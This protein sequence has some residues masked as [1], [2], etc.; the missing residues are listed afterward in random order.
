MLEPGVPGRAVPVLDFGRDI[1]YVA[2]FQRAGGL[3]P[4]LIPAAAGCYQK[5][6]TSFVMDVPVV[7]APRFKGDVAHAH[8]LCGEHGQIACS[9]KILCKGGIRCV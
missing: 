1:D 7:A 3:A 6:L 5:D 2:G 8:T 9:Y 4:L